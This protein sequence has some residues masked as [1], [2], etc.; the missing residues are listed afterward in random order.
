MEGFKRPNRRARGSFTSFLYLDAE[1]TVSSLSALEGGLVDELR[2]SSEEESNRTSGDASQTE[3]QRERREEEY[4][5]QRTGYSRITTLLQ[6][7]RELGALG[8]IGAYPPVVYKLIQVSDL[9][10]FQADIRL[11]PFHQFASV[12]DGLAET[13]RNLGQDDSEFENLNR[14]VADL[15]YGKDRKR[16]TL[17]VFADLP[18]ADPGYKVA[19]ALKKQHVLVD[20]EELSGTATF[21]AQVQRKVADGQKIST[22]RLVRKTPMVSAIEEQMMLSVIPALKGVPGT[23]DIG[24]EAAE[25]DIILRK[26]A[27]IVK[28]LCIYR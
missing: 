12:V 14:E 26:P 22:A 5:R 20:L 19:M 8:T 9:Y 6:K 1:Q 3:N 7:L 24:L 15:F 16:Q 28:P 4:L 25:D 21:V 13:G 18:G 23:A 10:E 2:S 17:S 27:V 11:H